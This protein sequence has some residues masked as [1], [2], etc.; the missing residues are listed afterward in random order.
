MHHA[1]RPTVFSLYRRDLTESGYLVTLWLQLAME[2]R[3]PLPKPVIFRGVCAVSL[4]IL[5]SL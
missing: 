4:P 3:T 1:A 2:Q 5:L